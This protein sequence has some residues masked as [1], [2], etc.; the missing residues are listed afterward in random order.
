MKLAFDGAKA[1]APGTNKSLGGEKLKKHNAT[2]REEGALK[3][4]PNKQKPWAARS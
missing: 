4:H 1:P 2:R 3:T